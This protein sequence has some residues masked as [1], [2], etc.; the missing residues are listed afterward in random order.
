MNEHSKQE[1]LLNDVKQEQKSTKIFDLR[2]LNSAFKNQKT[3][4]IIVYG[5]FALILLIFI[6]EMFSGISGTSGKNANSGE[7]INISAGDYE[8]Q[9]EKELERAVS[10]INGV[11][12]LTIMV[13]LD[14][15]SETVY[16]ER[17]S[18]VR[19]VITPKVRGVAIICEGGDDII[20]KQK[21]VELVSRVLGIA[22]TRIS[23]TC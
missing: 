1:F 3:V 20:V 22:T 23:V 8:T 11:G 4:K 18:G 12:E 16:S 10:A 17:G 15:L 6:S 7:D 5:G 21:I 2:T 9:L 14:S 19:T 13:T